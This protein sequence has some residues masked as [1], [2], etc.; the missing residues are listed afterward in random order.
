[1]RITLKASGEGLP[2]PALSLR[3]DDAMQRDYNH[4]ASEHGRHPRK[5]YCR[6]CGHDGR[7]SAA[8]V[9]QIGA[10]QAACFFG[11]HIS[12][13]QSARSPKSL[14]RAPGLPLLQ[15]LFQSLRWGTRLDGKG[16]YSGPNSQ[17]G[18][19]VAQ[20]QEKAM[21]AATANDGEAKN[22]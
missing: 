12:L 8:V 10:A 11:M 17:S 18:E 1:M 13:L 5:P 14:D 22:G 3:P 7:E 19:I 20:C 6:D 2:S 9:T 15:Y 21:C 16:P 4:H